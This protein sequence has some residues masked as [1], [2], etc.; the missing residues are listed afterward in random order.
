VGGRV[1]EVR[2][3][4]LALF[5]HRE[6]KK[7]LRAS[8]PSHPHCLHC[9]RNR[10]YIHDSLEVVGQYLKAHFGAHPSERPCQE[11][12]STHPLLQ[13]AEDMFNGASSDGH[14]VRLPVESTLHGFEYMF[15]FTSSDAA[16]VAG[17]TSLLEMATRACAGPVHVQI[18]TI[19]NG[20]ESK[21]CALSGGASIL[22]VPGNVDEVAF[23]KEPFLPRR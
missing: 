23:G 17:R 20:L 18:H 8:V 3:V 4:E 14:C 15:V 1:N 6:R 16:I 2:C 7:P 11:V 21:N 5:E 12:C 13:R 19:L 10:K 22:I 9:P